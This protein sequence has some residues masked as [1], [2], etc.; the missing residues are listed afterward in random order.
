VGAA[1]LWKYVLHRLQLPEIAP[2][3]F[4]LNQAVTIPAK[5]VFYP[6]T[7]RDL[8]TYLSNYM[9]R[10]LSEERE[11]I[12]HDLEGV[13]EL[14]EIE[15][16]EKDVENRLRNVIKEDEGMRTIALE[17]DKLLKRLPKINDEDEE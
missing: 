17:F 7:V 4:D 5:E 1:G 16:E 3:G 15:S 10:A 6:K 14:T 12:E 8:L 2:Q 9:D 13:E 11:A